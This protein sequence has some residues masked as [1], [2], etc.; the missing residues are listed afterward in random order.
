MDLSFTIEIQDI[1]H[2]EL[3]FLSKRGREFKYVVSIGDPGYPE[4]EKLYENDRVVLRMEF[5][6]KDMDDVITSHE[7]LPVRKHVESIINFASEIK[8]PDAKLLCHCKAGISRSTAAGLILLFLREKDEKKAADI[9][10][11]LNSESLPNRLMIHYADEI[12]GSNLKAVTEEIH[13][14]RAFDI[15]SHLRRRGQI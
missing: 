7:T 8:E 1:D 11:E 9:L 13:R 15:M 14:K 10:S 6:D 12:L 2:A 3:L 4:P 5:M